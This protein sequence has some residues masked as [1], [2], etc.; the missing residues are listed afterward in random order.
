M[1]FEKICSIFAKERTGKIKEANHFFTTRIQQWRLAHQR[2]TPHRIFFN[3][4]KSRNQ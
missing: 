2:K 4:L 1:P 3:F